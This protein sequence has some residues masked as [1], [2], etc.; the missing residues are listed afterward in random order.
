M[1]PGAKKLRER[2]SGSELKAIREAKELNAEAILD[3]LNRRDREGRLR[4][5]APDDCKL[6]MIFAHLRVAGASKIETGRVRD[7]LRKNWPQLS[8]ADVK[9]AQ[10]LAEAEIS[11]ARKAEVRKGEVTNVT[12]Q[13]GFDALCRY[14]LEQLQRENSK[15]GQDP[16]LYQHGSELVRVP[17]APNGEARIEMLNQK[18]FNHVLNT[19]APYRRMQGDDGHISASA[20][21]DV[22]EHLFSNPA[23]PVP[24]LEKIVTVPTFSANGELK[25]SAGFDKVSGLLYLPSQGLDIPAIPR[26][27]LTKESQKAAAFLV[28]LFADFPFDG[29][30]REEITAQR[31]ASLVNYLALLLTP[32]VAPIFDDVVPAHLLTKP[33][34]GTGASLLAEACMLIADGRAELRPPLSRNEE[35][36]RK[37][38]FSAL[39]T[40]KNFLVYDNVAGEMDSATFASFLTS[41]EWTDRVLGRSG[42]RTVRNA[43][44]TVL[45]GINPG[46]SPELQ[47]RLSLI[48]LDAKIPNPSE[49][50]GFKIKGDFKSHIRA[51]RGEIIAACLT[52]VQHWINKDMPAASGKALASFERWHVTLG[53]I[54]EAAGFKTFQA[55][56]KDLD[57]VTYVEDD[58]MQVLIEA[59]YSRARDRVDAMGMDADSGELRDLAKLEEIALPVKLSRTGE[60]FDFEPRAFGKYLASMKERTFAVDGANISLV[61]GARSNGRTPWRLVKR[62][63][64]TA[65]ASSPSHEIIPKADKAQAPLTTDGLNSSD[66][67]K[68]VRMRQRRRARGQSSS[69]ARMAEQTS[70]AVNPF[71]KSR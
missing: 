16:A 44:A 28:D 25:Q 63:S 15:L 38:L 58:P 59:W 69:L 9:A 21:R 23:L 11:A 41:R 60:D 2:L 47:R 53:G 13:H 43:S 36:R 24:A 7:A 66:D 1:T 71:A 70:D 56:R 29:L 55:N 4:V 8:A 68:V 46:F 32:F 34:P 6:V 39:Q 62:K 49:R 37:A 54:L 42:E 10:N 51:H 64:T 14:G 61:Q 31:P 17:V 67:P 33:A 19:Q 40:Q 22:A 5:P 35:E 48:K 20:P 3:R 57:A 52:L 26:G 45:T 30:T 12:D 18:S 27:D 65:P 50:V